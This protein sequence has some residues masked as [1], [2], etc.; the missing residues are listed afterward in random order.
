VGLHVAVAL[1][2]HLLDLDPWSDL[3]ELLTPVFANLV[4]S[5]EEAAFWNVGPIDIRGQRCDARVVML[6]WRERRGR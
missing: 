4:S 5:M 2:C 6:R 1:R 3:A